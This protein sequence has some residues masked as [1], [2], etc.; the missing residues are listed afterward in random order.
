MQEFRLRRIVLLSFGFLFVRLASAAVVAQPGYTDAFYNA[1]VAA[2]LARGAGLTADFV[3]S[4]VE[5]PSLD[6]LPLASHRFWMP[7]ATVVQALG[8]ALGGSLLG[9]FRAAQVPVLALA[10]LV[11]FVT[12]RVA[13]AVGASEGAALVAA[14]LVGL[15]GLF[16]PWWVTLDGFALAALAGTCFFL[17][18]RGAASGSTYS[19]AC[20]GLAVGVLFLARAEGA[21]FGLALLALARRPHSRRAALVG[22]AVAL[23]IGLAWLARGLSLEGGFD[24]AARTVFLVRYEDFFALAVPGGGAALAERAGALVT[25]AVT[26]IALGLVALPPLAVAGAR[27]RWSDAGVRAWACL[28]VVVYL[29]ESLAVPLHATRGSYIHSLAAFVPFAVALATLG[30]EHVLRHAGGR[31]RCFAAAGALGAT[32]VLSAAALVQWSATYDPPLAA[33]AAASELLPPDGSPVLALD[34][35]AWR[36]IARRPV[37]VTPSEGAAAAACVVASYGATAVVL[38]PT[39]FHAYD[40]LYEGAELPA[41]LGPPRERGGVKVFPVVGAPSCAR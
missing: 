23:S 3:W 17:L 37:I 40:R 29:A 11:P 14:G 27:L 15:G 12:W 24:L 6:A 22:S 34:A 30:A 2:R 41:W 39:R 4:F 8:V 16:A 35:A 1:N 33:R 31:A 38:E 25:D 7:L 18:Y 36:W 28:A 20:A 10:A 5:A 32:A 19:G 9:D 26:V 21:L 13:R